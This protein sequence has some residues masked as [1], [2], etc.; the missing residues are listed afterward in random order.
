MPEE[1]LAAPPVTHFVYIPFILFIGGIV[2]FIIGR[3]AGIRAG[4]AE[5]LGAFDD[6]DDL[7]AD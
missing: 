4:Q 5:Y 1:L 2:G 3:K 6:D 7:L